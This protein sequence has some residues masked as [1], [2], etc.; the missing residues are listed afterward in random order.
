MT[1]PIRIAVLLLMTVAACPAGEPLAK[2]A[3]NELPRSWSLEEIDKQMPGPRG[4]RVY[5]LAWKIVEDDR[6]LRVE[7][8]LAI[9]VFDKNEGYGLWHLWRHPADKNL[10]WQVAYTHVTGEKNTKYFPGLDLLHAKQ[11][12]NRPGN[13]ELYASLTFEEVNW[14][15][16]LEK[17]WKVVGCGV[18]E[19][20]WEE[21]IGEKPAKFFSTAPASPR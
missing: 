9:R 1:Q 2:P 20:S 3:P 16:E 11:F 21:V 4:D 6:P 7:S 18:C 12:K 8:C 19:K 15:F 10:K 17:D 14:S 5:V 13:K